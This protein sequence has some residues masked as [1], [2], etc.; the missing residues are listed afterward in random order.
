MAIWQFKVEIIPDA[1]AGQRELIPDDEW[2]EALWWLNS[3]PPDELLEELA[4]LLPSHKSW[5]DDLS[6]WGDQQS[7]LVEVWREG[8]KVESISARI[9]TRALNTG[10]VKALLEIANK[11]NCRLAY[12]RYRKV[13]PRDYINLVNA[14]LASQNFKVMRDPELWLPRMAA[15]VESNSV[16][17]TSS[18]PGDL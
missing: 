1:V 17:A 15:E 3:P 10:F 14:L 7:D 9:D 6:Q 8:E 16:R 11:W 12:A 13:L 18:A 2:E 4:C 5:S